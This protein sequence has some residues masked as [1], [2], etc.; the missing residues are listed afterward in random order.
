MQLNLYEV[1]D[2]VRNASTREAKVNV[3]RSNVSSV[4][5][6]ALYLTYAPHIHFFTVSFPR[7]YRPDRDAPAG[8]GWSHLGMELR[9]MY[10]FI[11]D[12]PSSKH[13]SRDK[14]EEL[15]VQLLESLE[16]REAEV[17]ISIF[18]KHIV[19]VPIELAK[20][21]FPATVV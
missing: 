3:L 16:P 4:L 13:L 19:G 10:L 2:Q 1:F 8:M 18:Q 20:E 11:N 6:D 12:H 21:A 7:Q 15:L 17:V 14:K 9:R 5:L